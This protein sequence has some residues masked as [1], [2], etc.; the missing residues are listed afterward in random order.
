MQDEWLSAKADTIQAYADAKDLKNFCSALKAVYGPTSS[1]TSSLLSADGEVM[2]ID[3]EKILERWAE[4]F[5]S[6]LN[7]P[8]TI[9]DEAIER[10]PQTPVGDTMTD[11]SQRKR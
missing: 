3:N 7:R 4:H 11:P 1:G 10:L 2:L 5:N 8:S 6:A 9:N